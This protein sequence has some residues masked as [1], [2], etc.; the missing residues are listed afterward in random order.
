MRDLHHIHKRK[1]LHQKLEKYPHPQKWIRFLDKFL[2]IA[3]IVGPAMTI[4][5]I[6]KIY[7]LRDASSIALSTWV[8]FAILDIPWIIYGVVHKEKPIVIA[9]ILWLITNIFVIVGTILYS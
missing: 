4:P 8:L 2:I 3:A 5:Q 6:V 7:S 9:Y 1:R